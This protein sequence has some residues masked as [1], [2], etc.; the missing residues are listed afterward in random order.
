MNKIFILLGPTASGKSALSMKLS[1]DFPFEIIN[2]DLYSIYR[3]LD[4]GTAK[5]SKKDME[6]TKHYLVD[7]RDPNMKYNVS[8]FCSDVSNC[9]NTIFMRNKVPLIVG[10]SMMYVYQLING[11]THEYSISG[12]D[13]RVINYIQ[14][15]YTDRTIYNSLE[16]DDSISLKN[17]NPNDSYRIEKLLERSISPQNNTKQHKGLKNIC[18]LS[19]YTMFIDVQNREFLRDNIYKRTK[20]MIKQGLIKEVQ[21]LVATYKLTRD[22]QSMKAIGY[23]ETI[24]YLDDKINFN[25][26]T[27]TIYLSTRQLAKRQLTWKNKFEIHLNLSYPNIDYSIV[28]KFISKSL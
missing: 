11:L 24:D 6:L 12:S 14:E 20:K 1:K 4:I 28:S 19:I 18:D 13:R 10:G 25:E 21:N 3:G 26:L 5:P 9:I 27:D 17:I 15:V 23:K 16:G 7:N 22:T 2:A 8:M